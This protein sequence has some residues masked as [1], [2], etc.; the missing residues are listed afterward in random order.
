MESNHEVEMNR[1][2]EQLSK[3]Q[4]TRS[5]QQADAMPYNETVQSTALPQRH[6]TQ[7]AMPTPQYQQE[8]VHVAAPRSHQLTIRR[9]PPYVEG[10][11]C[12]IVLEGDR[13]SIYFTM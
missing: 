6:G 8:E 4:S 12:W 11:A 7:V 13:R 3:I 5:Q 2:L 9:P 1:V 10:K